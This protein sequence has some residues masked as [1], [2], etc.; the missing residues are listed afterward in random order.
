MTRWMPAL[1]LL[2][3]SMAM[4]TTL[5]AAPRDPHLVAAIFPPWWPAERTLAAAGEAGAVLRLGAWPWIV[6]VAS[7]G[8]DIAPV[9]HAAGALFLVDPTAAGTCGSPADLAA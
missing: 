1:A 7:S 5:V 8:P 3:L 6:V 4:S 9:L 2:A